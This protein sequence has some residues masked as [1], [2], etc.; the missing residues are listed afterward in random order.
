MNSLDR[1]CIST[2]VVIE[3]VNVDNTFVCL[4]AVAFRS[5]LSILVA[6]V[7]GDK[8]APWFAGRFLTSLARNE[9]WIVRQ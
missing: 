2:Y 6:D 9:V 1:I 7:D 8:S 5:V 3:K 4:K